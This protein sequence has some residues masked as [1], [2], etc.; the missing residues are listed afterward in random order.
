MILEQ[1]LQRRM[2]QHFIYLYKVW[3]I[4]HLK[5]QLNQAL[6]ISLVMVVIVQLADNITHQT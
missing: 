5:V 3:N 4:N 1:L 6:V 2:R